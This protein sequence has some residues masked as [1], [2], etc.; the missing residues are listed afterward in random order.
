ME[1]NGYTKDEM[2]FAK[3]CYQFASLGVYELFG[4]K[5]TVDLKFMDW[6]M[7]SRYTKK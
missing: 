5:P 7:N 1:I 2:Q 6:Y 3:M 4:R